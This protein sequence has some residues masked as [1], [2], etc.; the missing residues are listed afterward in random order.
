MLKELVVEQAS[1]PTDIDITQMVQFPLIT[2]ENINMEA[3]KGLKRRFHLNGLKHLV[4][5]NYIGEDVLLHVNKYTS[6]MEATAVKKQTGLNGISA[7]H[8]QLDR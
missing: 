7:Y 4:K 2:A 5:N 6:D 1:L 3:L 8:P